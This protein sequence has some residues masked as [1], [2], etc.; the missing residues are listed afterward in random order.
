MARPKR[1]A[2]T[3]TAGTQPLAPT[4]DPHATNGSGGKHH[5]VQ[6]YDEEGHGWEKRE[7][8]RD[9]YGRIVAF[10][11]RHLLEESPA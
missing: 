11:K 6:W 2:G 7:T 10:L 1:R 3:A 8:K 9:A 4:A 5:E